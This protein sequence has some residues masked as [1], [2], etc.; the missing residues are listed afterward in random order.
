MSEGA[1]KVH[2]KVQEIGTLFSSTTP[3]PQ[4]FPR[5]VADEQKLLMLEGAIDKSKAQFHPALHPRILATAGDPRLGGSC[6]VRDSLADLPNLMERARG[7]LLL[8]ESTLNVNR[9]FEVH[10]VLP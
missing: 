3:E 8:V 5:C 7:K 10:V 4:H 9:I 6:G 2:A 1:S